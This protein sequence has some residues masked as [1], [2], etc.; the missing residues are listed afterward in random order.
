M[1]KKYSN[2]N[3][4]EE[5]NDDQK[6]EFKKNRQD[7][8]NAK[9]INTIASG[10]D[11][12]NTNLA[13][14]DFSNATLQEAKFVKSTL[15]GANFSEADLTKADFSNAK[16][17]LSFLGN[18][19]VFIATIFF[20]LLSAF[21]TAIIVT[22]WLYFKGFIT[23]RFTLWTSTW[24][25]L[26]SFFLTIF[27]RS[28]LKE[29]FW[30][31]QIIEQF[32]SGAD[33]I[34]LHVFIGTLMI[35]FVLM[36]A[37][38]D[39]SRDNGEKK[40]FNSV[41][42]TVLFLIIAGLLIGVS[43]LVKAEW[44]SLLIGVIGAALGAFF[45]CWFSR[46][47]ISHK[48]EGFKWLWEIYAEFINNVGDVTCFN[49]ANLNDA[50]FDSA[51]IKGADFRAKEIIRTSWNKVEFPEFIRFGNNYLKYRKVRQLIFK[52]TTNGQEEF[53][54]L[55]LQG[56]NLK[57]KSL[58][59]SQFIGT[60]LEGAN[61]QEAHLNGA[62]FKNANLSGANFQKARLNDAHLE[63][64]NLSG[65]NLQEARLNGA[66]LENAN[67]NGANL[68]KS[69]LT[70]ACIHN[71]SIGNTTIIN[72]IDCDFVFKAIDPESFTK[73]DR[74]R[75]PKSGKFETGFF[76]QI[77]EK[78]KDVTELLLR[79][80]DNQEALIAAFK[81]LAEDKHYIFQGFD[82]IGDD[83]IV[84]V[85]FPEGIDASEG[86]SRFRQTYEEKQKDIQQEGLQG[87]EL[88][89]ISKYQVILKAF[90]LGANMS[91]NTIIFQR[92]GQ[93]IEN[94][95]GTVL[96]DLTVDLSQDLTQAA[97]EIQKLL[98]QLKIDGTTD[99]DAQTK[100]AE[101]LANQA[102]EK[103]EFKNKLNQWK[104]LLGD[105]VAKTSISE[106]VKRVIELAL[107]SL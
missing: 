14:A 23:E 88:T 98:D 20:S 33:P 100:V 70:R 29:N 39:F 86:E 59:G 7:L 92:D 68:Q 15:W 50:I 8:V 56:I 102:K 32:W 93:Y 27:I 65:A 43:G 48:E 67:L 72:N 103:P 38:I 18:V 96:R 81:Q 17:G 57:G 101:S 58:Q 26:F 83:A 80:E 84:K 79:S 74:F 52:A 34:T 40:Y 99:D 54:G 30:I 42:W 94:N 31:K 78:D 97:S 36:G 62:N 76:E 91:G 107:N 5:L 106:A 44:W 45:G 53:N 49:Q 75:F 105:T 12:S 28:K 66:N 77:I 82:M 63:N 47:S 11:F 46:W 10:I 25:G 2:L 16:M 6:E 64:A 41:S 21:P 90:E 60:I 89:Q 24:I 51:K 85:K 3:L 22:F 19:F 55:N 61:F 35:V 4:T 13:G 69:Y 73:T 37:I 71:W 104:K 87:S 1:V 9:F 95:D